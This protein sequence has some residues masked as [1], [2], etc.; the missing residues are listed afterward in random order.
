MYMLLIPGY[1]ENNESEI[2][3]YPAFYSIHITNLPVIVVILLPCST[4][5]NSTYSNFISPLYKVKEE[6][7]KLFKG[8]DTFD[9]LRINIGLK[10]G[11]VLPA[12]KSP[13]TAT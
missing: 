6:A 1:F 7:L 10:Q 5:C 2:G 12:A 3:N 13:Q 9:L 11:L 8:D 4:L